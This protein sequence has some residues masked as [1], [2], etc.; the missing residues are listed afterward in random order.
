MKTKKTAI[1]FITDTIPLLIVSFLGIFKLKLFIQVL[2][3]ETLGL[4]Q[5]FSQIMIYVALVDGGLSSAVLYSL[6]KPHA[7][8]D[9]RKFNSILAGAYKTFSKIGMIV[10][11]IATIISFVVPFFIKDCTFNYLYVVVTFILFSLSNVVGYF[12]V[13][14]NCLLEVKEKKY[15]YNLTTQIGQIVLSITEILML[16]LKV[17]FEYILIMHS[18][19]KLLASLVEVYICKKQ[20]PDIKIIQKEKNYEFKKHINSL[21]FHKING[22]V[23]SN[24][25]TL[26]ISSFLGLNEVAIYSTYNY[27][28]NMLKN[29]LGKISASMTAMVGNFLVKSKDKMYE[30]YQ[31]F[32]SMLFFIA[33]V[34]CTPLTLAI[35]DFINIFYEGEIATNF[36]IAISFVAILFTFI[37]KMDTN[38]F[39]NAGGLYKETKYCALTDTVTNLI[40]SLTL[41]H[42]IG[43]P[44]VLIATAI[45][46]FIAEY[47]LKTK[48]VHNHIFSISPKSYYL[49]NIKFFVLYIIDLIIGY[50]IINLFSIDSILIW[51]I[52]FAIY[53]IINSLIILGIFTIMKENKFIDRVKILLK[54][55]AK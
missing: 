13:P 33:I 36:L 37:I 46:V 55:G 20:F 10:F 39:V 3:N 12:F 7:E 31:E 52:I 40:L 18:I 21:L 8:E 28:I 14:Y 4:Y 17:K 49:K 34:L 35:D 50:Y 22:L 26:I 41:V 42:L 24:I 6:Y 54:R 16:L 27:I 1:N 48:V 2:G 23:G 11:S 15:I 47:I 44:G 19:V 51:F 32:N 43:I 25:D 53:T 9:K 38:M 29:I 5:L 45:S 30:L